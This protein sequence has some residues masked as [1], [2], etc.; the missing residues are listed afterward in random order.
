MT[1]DTKII[2]IGSGMAGYMLSQSIRQESKDVKIVMITEKDGRFYPKPMLST[3]LFHHKSPEDIVTSSASEMAEK[4]Q[5]EIRTHTK[6][7]AVDTKAKEVI[8]EG[9]QKEA[10]DKLVLATGSH[11]KT[12]GHAESLRCHSINAIEDY[13]GFLSALVGVKQVLIVGSGLVGVEFAHDLLKSGHHVTM[14]SQEEAPLSGLIPEEIGLICK[15]HLISMGLNWCVDSGVKS[16]CDE[17]EKVTVTFDTLT[18][19]QFDIVL[20]AIGIAPRVDLAESMGLKIDQGVVTDAYGQSSHE[21]IYA[22]GDCAKI[23][24]LNLTYVAPIKQQAKAISQNLLG[25]RVT[26]EYP[27]MPVVVKVPTLPL[28]LVPVRE[29]EVKG[30]WKVE[31]NDIEGISAGFY[32][33]EGKIKGF[34]LVG[35]A[36]KERNNWLKKMPASIVE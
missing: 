14:L 35:E 25:G 7:S 32:D 24:G 9:G 10:Y 1:K 17:K 15:K 4:Y 23:Y 2:I 29:V 19:K 30:S 3:A 11:A 21:D 26:I 28:T 31:K 34:A 36:T 12:L 16:M 22:I 18:P 8:L 13:E 20:S 6:V 5:L 27:A 33:Q